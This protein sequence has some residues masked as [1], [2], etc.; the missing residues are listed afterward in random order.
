MKKYALILVLCFAITNIDAQTKKTKKLISEIEGQWEQDDNG[1]ITYT[2]IIEDLNLPKDKIYTRALEYFTYNY[3]DGSSVIQIEDKEKGLIIG[4]GVYKNVHIGNSIIAYIFDT[5]HILRIDVKENR[6]RIMLT[7]TNYDFTVSGGDTPDS[8]RKEVIS[9]NYPI[10]PKGRI[11]NQFGKAF[12]ASHKKAQLT[13]LAIEKTLKE[14]STFK[15][16]SDW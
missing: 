16:K 14:G 11:R 1:N 8:T 15:K 13:L 9:Q 10:N 12:Y 6:A 7:L 3:G 5:W 2:R 4:K